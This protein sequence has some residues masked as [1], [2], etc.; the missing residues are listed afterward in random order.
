MLKF[1]P[2]PY[3]LLISCY[4]TT[5]LK[6]YQLGGYVTTMTAVVTITLRYKNMSFNKE[7]RFEAFAAS[8]AAH[9]VTANKYA[10]TG[11]TYTI[12]CTMNIYYTKANLVIMKNVYFYFICE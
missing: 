2:S 9:V 10:H 5:K 12:S 11:D 3:I 1:Y 7:E 4:Y 8:S 6:C